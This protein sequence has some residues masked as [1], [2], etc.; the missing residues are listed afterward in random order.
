[1]I[2]RNAAPLLYIVGPRAA[3]NNQSRRLGALVDSVNA[4]EPLPFVINREWDSATHLEHI[5]ERSDHFNYARK[6]IPI[7]FFTTGMHNDYHLPGDEPGK[8][9]YTKMARVAQ[10]IRDVGVAVGNS[11]QR[12]R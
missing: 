6:G 11:A 4:A 7:V 10:L 5:Y 2:G 3:P 1:M 9:D 8:I 12:P